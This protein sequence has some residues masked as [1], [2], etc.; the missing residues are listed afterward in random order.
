MNSMAKKVSSAVDLARGIFQ[1]ILSGAFV[2]RRD[3]E[4]PRLSKSPFTD[5]KHAL[6]GD[7]GRILDDWKTAI[8]KVD[9]ART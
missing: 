7:Y 3:D 4:Y 2:A 6:G 9:R 5:D 1:S 8:K